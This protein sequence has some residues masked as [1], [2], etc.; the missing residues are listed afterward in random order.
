M[1]KIKRCCHQAA[2]TQL[3]IG[4]EKS[5]QKLNGDCKTPKKLNLETKKVSLVVKSIGFL[6]SKSAL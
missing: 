5:D 6:G 3:T 2:P 4:T 1:E